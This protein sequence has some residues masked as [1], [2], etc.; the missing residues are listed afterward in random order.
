MG[1]VRLQEL[2]LA[3]EI[4]RRVRYGIGLFGLSTK[5]CSA[6]R[7][8]LSFAAYLRVACSPAIPCVRGWLVQS[9][10]FSR[11]QGASC[12]E[13]LREGRTV[14]EIGNQLTKDLHG[15]ILPSTGPAPQYLASTPSLKVRAL[16]RQ[17]G[18]W[19]R[20]HQAAL[21]VT[22]PMSWQCLEFRC[23]C[24]GGW[25][26]QNV[27]EASLMIYVAGCE[28]E[29]KYPTNTSGSNPASCFWKSPCQE[30]RQ[31]ILSISQRIATEIFRQLLID[32]TPFML[33]DRGRGAQQ[34]RLP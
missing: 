18:E 23:R 22:P 1:L 27:P 8:A 4:G 24:H 3:P 21:I 17:Q 33:S 20:T 30:V 28:L 7:F 25:K 5:A 32:K 15:P 34:M 13:F 29:T 31:R 10:Q 16:G 2:L 26:H 14:D 11:G 19:K 12:E 9:T 6:P